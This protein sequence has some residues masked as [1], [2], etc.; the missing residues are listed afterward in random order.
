MV[1]YSQ[2]HKIHRQGENYESSK[3]RKVLTYER[4]QIRYAADLSTDTWQAR[5]EW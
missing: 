3:G 1:Y 5:K 2:I 4:I